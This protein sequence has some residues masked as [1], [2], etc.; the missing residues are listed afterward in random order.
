MYHHALSVLYCLRITLRNPPAGLPSAASF[1]QKREFRANPCPAR[2]P[3]RAAS[4]KRG[5]A[6]LP[7]MASQHKA[8]YSR[9]ATRPRI[10]ALSLCL[11]LVL[12]AVIPSVPGADPVDSN[13]YHQVLLAAS[14]LQARTGR[15][16]ALKQAGK[17]L[18]TE[19]GLLDPNPG[20]SL[21]P[22]ERG[23]LQQENQDR[24]EL[25][26]FIA[27]YSAP[28][29]SYERVANE[30]AKNIWKEWPPRMAAPR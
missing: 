30:Y 13:A 25:F 10:P 19:H 24:R 22:T 14:R 2:I 9:H 26:E 4:R 12:T 17:A 5:P 6:D 3:G 11:W 16:K 21:S 7:G 18:G 15:I 28:P 27:K 29:V 8:S 1:Q 23:L 20:N